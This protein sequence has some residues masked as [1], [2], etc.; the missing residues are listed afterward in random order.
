MYREIWIVMLL[1][2]IILLIVSLVLFFIWGISDLI[3]ELS[4]KKA[5]RQIKIMQEMNLDSGV[6]DKYSTS[7][8]YCGIPGG[9]LVSED[10]GSISSDLGSLNEIKEVVTSSQEESNSQFEDDDEETATSYVDES[11][12]TYIEEEDAST[13]YLDSI[14]IKILEEQSSL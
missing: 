12:T 3:D 7:D 13:S 9:S 11:A 5:K 6:F 8:I 10:I 2:G 1:I 14:I 4:G